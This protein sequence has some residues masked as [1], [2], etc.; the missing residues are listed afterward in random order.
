MAK[1]GLKRKRADEDQS[2]VEHSIEAESEDWDSLWRKL[3]AAGWR[4]E[5]GRRIG[6]DVFYVPHAYATVGVYTKGAGTHTTVNNRQACAAACNA[7]PHLALA[8]S[9]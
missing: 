1:G 6:I 7:V 2:K 3:S 9:R 4:K 5:D 8:C